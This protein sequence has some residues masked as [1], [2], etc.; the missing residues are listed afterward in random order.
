MIHIYSL[1]KFPNIDMH[2]RFIAT[3]PKYQKAIF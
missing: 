1:K 2:L 3:C